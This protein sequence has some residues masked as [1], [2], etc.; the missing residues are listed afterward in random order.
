MECNGTTTKLTDVSEVLTASI[1]R[2]MLIVTSE[3]INGVQRYNL[4][5]VRFEHGEYEDDCLWDVSPCSLVETDLT[6][7]RCLLLD[8]L[9][10]VGSKH[11]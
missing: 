4:M 6:F 1:I 7:R 11:L 3:I 10:D 9:D 2:V 8:R 5:F